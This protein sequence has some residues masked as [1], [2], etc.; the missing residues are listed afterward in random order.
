MGQRV[1]RPLLRNVFLAGGGWAVA[2]DELNLH[3]AAHWP[4]RVARQGGAAQ[5]RANEFLQLCPQLNSLLRSQRFQVVGQRL[6]KGSQHLLNPLFYCGRGLVGYPPGASGG[7]AALS[8]RECH[9]YICL[10][11]IA[12]RIIANACCLQWHGHSPDLDCALNPNL[13]S[14]YRNSIPTQ[15]PVS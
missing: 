6:I 5:L 15:R 3:H 4:V 1:G 8:C 9:N 7:I 11:N 2:T 10:P 12:H 14:W 13:D